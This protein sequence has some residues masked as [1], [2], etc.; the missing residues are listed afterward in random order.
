MSEAIFLSLGANLGDRAANLDR[1]LAGLQQKAVR[2]LT[3]S[4]FYLTD[5]VG[6][7]EQPQFLNIACLV[8]TAL[9]PGPLLQTCLAVEEEMG[10]V[11]WIDKGPRL[12][13]IDLLFYG[14]LIIRTPTLTV[15]HPELHAR[16]FVLTPLKEIAPGFQDPRSRRT[17][18]QLHRECPDRTAVLRLSEEEARRLPAT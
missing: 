2:L 9:A 6:S 8:A 15:P 11:R 17:V 3:R 7:V 18:L 10:R 1:A 13:D 14:D 5:P 16:N 4:S 12:V